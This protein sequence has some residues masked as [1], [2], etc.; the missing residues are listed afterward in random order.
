MVLPPPERSN[1]AA[2]FLDARVREGRG[3]R[4][5][6][7]TEQANLTYAEVQALANRYGHCL[8]AA[9]VEPED[10]VLIALPDGA[11]FVGAFF[12]TLKLGA[13]VVMV[14]PALP[15]D[16]VAHM[17]GVLAGRVW[18]W[19]TRE[20]FRVRRGCEGRAA[21]AQG[22][23]VGDPAFNRELAAAS[24]DLDTFPSHRDDAAIW[25]FSGGTTGRPKAVVQTHR[26]FINTT[27]LY[28]RGSSATS[29]TT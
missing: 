3:S 27:E 28:G 18:W 22:L 17:L 7:R 24:P 20:R 9:G 14:N 25:L 8:A 21:H 5:A 12:G 4:V 1:I 16:D 23:V 2:A 19:R 11:D 15:K 13:V 29:R 6:L 10:R 26:S